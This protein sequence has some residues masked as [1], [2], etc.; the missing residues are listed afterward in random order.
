MFRISYLFRTALY[1]TLFC[2]S[3]ADVYGAF[4]SAKGSRLYNDSGEEVG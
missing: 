2:L 4:L 1:L 3:F